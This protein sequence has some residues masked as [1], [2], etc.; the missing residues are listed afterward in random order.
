MQYIT[1]I[2]IKTNSNNLIFLIQLY[3]LNNVPVNTLTDS[4][5]YSYLQLLILMKST[6]H[7]HLY[8]DKNILVIMIADRIPCF[9]NVVR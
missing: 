9:P 4:A 7:C 8:M 6:E 1:C 2:V 5:C 3:E